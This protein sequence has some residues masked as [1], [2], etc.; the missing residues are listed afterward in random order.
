MSRF[1]LR[2]EE[3]VMYSE[4]ALTTEE[5]IRTRIRN[6]ITGEQR[7]LPAAVMR[8]IEDGVLALMKDYFAS[9]PEERDKVYE[10][11][12]AQLLQKVR[13]ARRPSKMKHRSSGREL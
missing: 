1:T 9:E 10:D 8:P 7:A 2:A 4:K 6:A 13:S 11:H 12:E 3:V 5:R